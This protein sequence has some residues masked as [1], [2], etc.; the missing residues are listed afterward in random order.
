MQNI[1]GIYL[2][3][4][5]LVFLF[6]CFFSRTHSLRETIPFLFPVLW[7]TFLSFSRDLL[8]SPPF[9]VHSANRPVDRK[10]PATLLSSLSIRADSVELPSSKVRASNEAINKSTAL[11]GLSTLFV[12]DVSIEFFSCLRVREVGPIS[13]ILVESSSP[14][15]QTFHW[16]DCR[17]LNQVFFR[18]FV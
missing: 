17:R 7:Q 2:W 5:Q 9:A 13:S 1:W 16:L 4:Y 15:L 12:R 18:F 10:R 11:T 3:A 8:L 14:T 6:S